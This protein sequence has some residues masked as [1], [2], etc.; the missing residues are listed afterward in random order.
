MT[1]LDPERTAFAV[2]SIQTLRFA[3]YGFLAFFVV[4]FAAES[5]HEEERLLASCA[6]HGLIGSI[7]FALSQLSLATAK[8]LLSYF[9]KGGRT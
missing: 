7:S 9:T 4:G 1:K 3:G 5:I 8:Y 6:V 2:P